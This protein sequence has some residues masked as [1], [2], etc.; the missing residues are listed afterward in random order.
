VRPGTSRYSIRAGHRHTCATQTEGALYCWGANEF[1]QLGIGAAASTS[2]PTRVPG[3]W[4]DV[5]TSFFH[6]CG[7]RARNESDHGPDGELW[8]W[9]WNGE[10][11]LGTGD[12]VSW[13]VPSRVDAHLW[14]YAMTG[15]AHTCGIRASSSLYCWGR[16]DHGQLGLGDHADRLKPRAVGSPVTDLYAGVAVGADH[17]GAKRLTEPWS[18]WCWGRNHRGQ[19]GI[20]SYA[21]TNVPTVVP[22]PAGE[23]FRTVYTQDSHT[24]GLTNPSGTNWCWGW[25]AFGQLGNGRPPGVVA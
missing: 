10:G 14:S 11:Q 15:Y 2:V 5:E 6:T 16:G 24:C 13:N 18:L 17:T 12:R 19:L 25:N 20:G 9:G 23:Y 8:C 7:V 21:S 3:R 4:W 22:A 1:G